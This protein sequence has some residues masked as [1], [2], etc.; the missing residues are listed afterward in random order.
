MI[1]IPPMIDNN[2]GISF[3]H[4]QAI[5]TANTGIRYRKLATIDAGA[6]DKA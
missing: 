5:V 1:T 4:I 3:S 6:L 2:G